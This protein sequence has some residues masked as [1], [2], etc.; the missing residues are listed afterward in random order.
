[1]TPQQQLEKMMAR[2]EPA[3]ATVARKALGK[4]RKLVPGAVEMVYDNYNALAIGF[5]PGDRPSEAVFSIA[6]YPNYVN[7]FFLQGKGLPDPTGRL[8][9]NAN[10]VRRIRL[11]S[12][13]TLDDPE[14]LELINVALHRAKVPIDAKQKRRL[15]IKSISKKQR[16]RRPSKK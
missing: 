10:R 4:M 5:V 12:A 6:L 16:P 15:V 1:M 11:E 14:I 8:E 9:G 7:L 2:Y 3:V 13:E